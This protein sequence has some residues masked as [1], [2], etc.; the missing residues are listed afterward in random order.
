LR[1]VGIIGYKKSGKTSLLV[2]L[3][4]EL[5]KS[6]LTISSVKHSSGQLDLPKTDTTLHKQF[7]KN[8]GA[9]TP[10]G[11]AIFLQ[12]PVSLNEMLDF[13][14]G[15]LVLV[16]GFKG[17]KTFPKIVCLRPEDDPE[18]LL[19][20]LEICIVGDTSRLKPNIEAPFLDSDKDI[21]Q[22]ARLVIEKAFK[23]PGLDCGACGYDT[24]YDMAKNIVKGSKT[25]DDCRALMSGVQIEID[26]KILPIKP[27]VSDIVQNTIE[28]MLS[29][30]KG[31]KK[32]KIEIKIE[33]RQ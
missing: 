23:L 28:G 20:G 27:F 25:I 17:E 9:I 18:T 24:C 19:D 32:G 3:A 5:V 33:I 14:R 2:K 13:L 21:S 4:Q 7:S 26:G 16:E 11:S 8:V 10:D 12:E 31:Y 1:V 15:D 22:I 6:G 30:L 29:A